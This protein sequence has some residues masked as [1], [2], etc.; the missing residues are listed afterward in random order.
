MKTITLSKWQDV[1][2]R[3]LTALAM[4]GALV[5]FF[6]GFKSVQLAS[7]DLLWVEL[8]RL[9]GFLLFAAMFALLSLRPRQSA[10]IWELAF[11]HKA[12]MT[13]ISLFI[14]FAQE[15]T[16]AGTFDGILALILLSAYFLTRA[17]RGWR[18]PEQSNLG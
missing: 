1:L 6:S 15:A 9:A 8:W 10:G 4:L 16:L 2:G 5:A 7:P 14:P 3:S 11:F 17:W 12:T 13:I 18:I